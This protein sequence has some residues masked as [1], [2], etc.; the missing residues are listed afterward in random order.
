[1][2]SSLFFAGLGPDPKVLAVALAADVLLGDPP[3]ALHPVA[4]I[5]RLTGAFVCRAPQN[6]AL[7][8]LVAGGVI[9]L[10]VCGAALGSV[11]LLSW[12]TRAIPALAFCL[13]A[14]VLK[15]TF[16]IKGLGA[17]GRVVRVALSDGR[18]GD[19]RRGLSALCSRDAASLDESQLAAATI[20]SLA[21]NLSDSFV[22]PLL[23]YIAFGLP[24]A[25][26]YRAANTLD[27]MIGYRGR[28][29]YLGKAAARFDDL[30]NL[31]PARLTAGLLLAAGGILNADV[32][33]GLRVLHRDR[34]T[35]ASPNAGWP[36]AAM[37]GL[38]GV[39]LE[40]PGHYQLGDATKA[41][42]AADIDRGWHIVAAAAALASVV[43]LSSLLAVRAHGV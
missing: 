36:M 22:A 35:T 43:V 9:V 6:G 30:L 1:V 31:I 39:T 14:A 4:W 23:A 20:E 38:L 13:G 3:N 7:R 41:L 11:V 16:A 21:E 40:K 24:G 29:E 12:A 25:V 28:Y 32:R 42:T 27:A 10:G 15:C 37:A 19:A 2:S 17:A 34:N 33:G 8:Q 26:V 5:G 18:V